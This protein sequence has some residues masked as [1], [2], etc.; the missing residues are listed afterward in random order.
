MYYRKTMSPGYTRDDFQMMQYHSGEKRPEEGGSMHSDMQLDV[1]YHPAED[2]TFVPYN[3]DQFAHMV[4]RV[5]KGG[6]IPMF[7][8]HYTPPR[9]SVQGAF[10]TKKG[11]V[12][13]PI[14]LGIAQ[15]EVRNRL[16]VDLT[17][18]HDLSP[19]SLK[20]VKNAASR[21]LISDSS[22]IPDE[23]MNDVTFEEKPIFIYSES[24]SRLSPIPDAEVKKGKETLRTMLGRKK[25]LSPQFEP[26]TQLSMF[27]D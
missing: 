21:G 7:E 13:F 26:H 22:D 14:M 6:Q 12:H 1:T 15:N 25:P 4:K 5:P 18:S 16:G 2:E 27:D 11:R 3:E 23:P 8:H 24:A 19:H 10:G 17:P 9:A 20:F